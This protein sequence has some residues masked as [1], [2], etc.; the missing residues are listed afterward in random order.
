VNYNQ[1]VPLSQ[2]LSDFNTVER[3]LNQYGEV[4]VVIDDS[5]RYCILTIDSAGEVT[6]K[7]LSNSQHKLS[8]KRAETMEILNKIGKSTFIEHYYD[9]KHN[10]T[11]ADDL[12]E[13]FTTNSK[14]SRKSKARRIFREG[15]QLEALQIIMNS[16]RLDPSIINKA[17]EIY[18]KENSEL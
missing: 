13:D 2:L 6:S 17:K 14:R 10:L 4:V 15:L 12:P 7:K 8:S 3:L 11:P 9:F 1:F 5:P 16:N 18:E